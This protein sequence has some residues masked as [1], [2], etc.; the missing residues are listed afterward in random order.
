ML[1]IIENK[2]DEV[3]EAILAKDA[4]DITYGEYKILDCKAKDLAF[5]A[6][7][8]KRNEEAKR[9][10]EDMAKLLAGTFDYAIGSRPSS[11][12]EPTIKEK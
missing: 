1:E 2:I 6:D 5:K 3:V 12:P 4:N 8:E 10:S 11:L 7:Q 9:R